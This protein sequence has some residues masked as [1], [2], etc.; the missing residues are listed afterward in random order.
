[1]SHPVVRAVPMIRSPAH[2]ASPEQRV[3]SSG[4]L[5]A[6]EQIAPLPSPDLP[7]YLT[8]D[9]GGK[10]FAVQVAPDGAGNG[11]TVQVWRAKYNRATDG[12][13]AGA[14]VVT[15]AN[16]LQ[17]WV[18]AGTYND[19]AAG[20][21]GNC[22]LVYTHSDAAGL[23]HHTYIGDSVFSFTTPSPIRDFVGTV[24]NS[25]VVYSYAATDSTLLNLTEQRQFPRPNDFQFNVETINEFFYGHH[26]VRADG[27]LDNL[28]EVA[29]RVY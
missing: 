14:H 6:V 18:G 11:Q 16:A 2:G 25:S 29:K 13:D 23:C 4:V 28:L 3:S 15:L 1:M 9:N 27:P 8:D 7:T 22:Y 17:V 19:L 10:A 20:R 12:F 21:Y 26:A 24:Q 5:D